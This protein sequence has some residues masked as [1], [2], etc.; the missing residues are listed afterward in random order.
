MTK[1]A[2]E[3]SATQAAEL[4]ESQERV[5]LLERQLEE[6]GKQ[7]QDAQKKLLERSAAVQQEA[8]SARLR[9]QE[10]ERM[11]EEVDKEKRLLQ[12]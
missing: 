3:R 1:A 5:K 4:R 12:E 11:A 9:V 7:A 8:E 2:A 10:L 6:A